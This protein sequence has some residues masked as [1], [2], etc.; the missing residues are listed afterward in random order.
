MKKFF[1]Y[2]LSC[3]LLLTIASCDKEAE[4]NDSIADGYYTFSTTFEYPRTNN[5]TIVTFKGTKAS[6]G[7]CSGTCITAGKKVRSP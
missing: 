1:H 3:L 6:N 2:L 5:P 7:F 4:L